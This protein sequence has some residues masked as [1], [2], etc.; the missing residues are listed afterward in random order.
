MSADPA[1]PRPLNPFAAL[2]LRWGRMHPYN[3]VHLVRLPGSADPAGVAAAAE[4]E[5][6]AF[7][8]GE[9]AA[10]EPTLTFRRTGGPS[11]PEV[12]LLA[13]GADPAAWAGDELNRPFAEG[14]HVPVRLALFP[15]PA[16]GTHV[17]GLAYEH[18]VADG[19]VIGRLLARVI[20]RLHGGDAPPAPAPDG[21]G[22]WE[23]FPEEAEPARVVRRL[24]EMFRLLGRLRWC[25][26]G[27]SGAAL[28]EL[29]VAAAFAEPPAGMLDG[30]RPAARRRGATIHDLFVAA[31]AEAVAA[32]TPKRKWRSRRKDLAV[33]NV[34]DL[35]PA[36][37]PAAAGAAGLYLGHFPVVCR[38]CHLD[39]FERLLRSVS[40]QTGHA[41][42]ARTY[43]RSL[44]DLT[45]SNLVWP[46]V[47]PE[48]RARHFRD[49]APMA[50][51]ISNLRMT[52]AGR[53]LSYRRAVPT[54]PTMPLSVSPTTA[55]G[56]LTI[57]FTWRKAV[58]SDDRIGGVI[59]SMLNRLSR[60]AGG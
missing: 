32:H 43:L 14:P 49:R 35:R 41:K 57:G 13:P 27:E 44:T 25:Y 37:G 30:L 42:A 4:A 56:R 36:A 38:G 20:A 5:L 45:F 6:S 47:R 12:R 33:G 11:A 2:M 10:D 9:L 8:L 55:A 15:E 26:R 39:E 48:H 18:W 1:G 22:Y 16:A 3:A 24:M 29:G 52:D 34:V 54:G 19:F 17:L 46:W 21:P 59:A 53:V 60:L 51:G 40:V 28:R 58:F 23:L 31:V 50:A 7:G